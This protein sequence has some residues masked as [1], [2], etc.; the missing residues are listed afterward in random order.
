MADLLSIAGNSV[1]TNQSALA[2]IGNNIANANTDGYVRQELDIRENLPTRAGTV[3]L[4]TG[5]LSA[6]VKRAYD[7]LVESSL[8]SSFSDLRSQAP[9]IDYTN[10]VVDLLGGENASLTPALDSF[11]NSFRDL[12]LD[13]SS[14]LRRNSVVSE[15]KG[16][17]SRLNEIG[18]QLRSIDSDTLTALKF[19]VTELNSL[20]EQL[21]MVNSKLSR[22]SKL[23]SQPANLLNTR[24]LLLQDISGLMKIRV[25]EA[26]N[27][28]V[29]VTL[30]NEANNLALVAKGKSVQVGL[31]YR[32]SSQPIGV[33]L[34]LDPSGDTRNLNSISS[35]EIG[36]YL[37]F[38]DT[39]LKNALEQVN[40]L[41]VVIANEVN[42]VLAKGMDLYGA[43]GNALFEIRPEI[44]VDT[45][46]AKSNIS[47]TTAISSIDPKNSHKLEMMFD[48]PNGRWIVKDLATNETFSATNVNNFLINGINISISGKP[49]DGDIVTVSTLD[50]QASNIRVV[51][52]DAKKLAAAELLGLTLGSENT[53]D[54]K[55]SVSAVIAT[56]GVSANSMQNQLVNNLHESSAKSYQASYLTPSFVVDSGITDLKLSSFSPLGHGSE[57]QVFTREG[58]HLFGS[59]TLNQSQ[60]DAMLVTQNGFES[61]A[62]YSKRYL[63]QGAAY[64][65]K[66]WSLGASGTSVIEVTDTGQ[67]VVRS[68]ARIIGQ[69]IP[70][71]SNETSQTKTLI[72][73]DA[74]KLNGKSLTALTLAAG[75]TLSADAVVTWLNSNISTHSLG[76]TASAATKVTLGKDKINL[77]S[78]SLSINGTTLSISSPLGTLSALANKINEST[79]TTGVRA[80][81]DALENLT[82]ANVP[83]VAS[84]TASSTI[85]LGSSE[86]VLK[87]TGAQRAAIK[88]EANRSSGDV[89]SKTVTLERTAATSALPSW[90]TEILGITETLSLAGVL[91][92]DLVVFTTGGT[93]DQM[94]YYAGYST[95]ESDPLYQ[96]QRITDVKF[97]STSNYQ[98]VDRATNTILSERTWSMGSPI[99]YGAISLTIEGQPNLGDVFS[100]DGNQAGVA[101]N[102]NALRLANLE[103]ADISGDGTTLKE[104]YLSILTEAGNSARRSV[105]AQEALDVVYQQVVQT[106]DAKAGVNLDEEA[107]D[108]LRFQQA[109]QA[110]AR[111]MRMANELFDSILRI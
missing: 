108:L 105:V 86:G 40:S 25:A 67:Q 60:K 89:S 6:G 87:L 55:A 62:T 42:G 8:R 50:S 64:L 111:V 16:L 65:G 39:T 94:S 109:Y 88:I 69:S 24:D 3:F 31:E 110:S 15:S 38:R 19:K 26:A 9:I 81:I 44:M 5:A 100:I 43:S 10:R 47:V 54:T 75:G 18:S 97:T 96:R 78:T 93:S 57:M 58:V 107:A 59:D 74:F 53:G 76:L 36:G 51:I 48:Q 73:A 91:E 12:G 68:E 85:T 70:S 72:A 98:I 41:A 2:V 34:I 83:G 63:N 22:Q 4:G 90:D 28:E 56:P 92:E 33:D 45:S 46:F 80:E 29:T 35:G 79:G 82:L 1:K 71:T 11:F 21:G 49:T 27:G 104:S 30:G 77:A 52:D 32:N 61:T 102:E 106:K 66:P 14:E 99:N 7:S 20:A 23:E 95:S 13:A 37:S 103:N 101:S 84:K 17:A